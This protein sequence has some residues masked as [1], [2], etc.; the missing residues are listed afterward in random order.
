MLKKNKIKTKNK[1]TFFSLTSLYGK[2][3][4]GFLIIIMLTIFFG[5]FNLYSLNN[6]KKETE[7]IVDHELSELLLIDQLRLNVS[8]RVS[9]TRAYV[10]FGYEAYLERYNI[11]IEESNQ[12]EEE[13][14]SKIDHEILD[15]TIEHSKTLAIQTQNNIFNKYDTSDNTLAIEN[16]TIV[17]TLTDRIIN[18]YDELAANQDAKITSS[19]E[20]LISNTNYLLIVGIAL[21]VVITIIGLIISFFLSRSISNPIKKVSERMQSISQKELNHEPLQTKRNDEVG[22]LIHATNDMTF[23]LQELLEEIKK[24]SGEVK[25]QTNHLNF[26]TDEVNKGSEQIAATMQEL[27]LGAQNQ[28]NTSTDLAQN[29]ASFHTI[30]QEANEKGNQVSEGANNVV[31]LTEDGSNVMQQSVQQMEAIDAIVKKSVNKV[32]DLRDQSTKI[33]KIVDVIKD[34]ADQTNLL[35]LNAAIEAARAGEHGKGFAVVADEVRKLAEQVSVSISDITSI[36]TD[37]TKETD[38]VTKTLET[39]YE[40]VEKGTSHLTTTK[41]TFQ[42][43]E[44]AIRDMRKDVTAISDNLGTIKN[45]SEKMHTA[46]EDIAAISEESAAGVEETTASTETTKEAMDRVSV[47]SKSLTDLTNNL[48][49]LI[50]KF[51]L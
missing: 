48:N 2:L 49:N 31:Q 18:G 25:K 45:S 26:T 37:I 6:I 51:K 30:I 8:E 44:T 40:Q 3:L 27:S 36:V 21:I 1:K 10:V 34:I 41:Q 28:A 19:G 16:L 7:N 4:S 39:G 9:L 20:T 22:D 43:I 13:L 50:N 29:M 17:N 42:S 11:L 32:S 38:S 24:T 35:A 33:N 5:A 47:A 14:Q 46:I 12:L 23:Q 15:K